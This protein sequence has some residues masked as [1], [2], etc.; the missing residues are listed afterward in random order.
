MHRSDINLAREINATNGKPLFGATR[1]LKVPVLNMTGDRSPHVDATV[2]FNG[3]LQPNK[4]TWMKIQDCAMV[5]EEQPGKVAEAVK[6][7]VQ[8]LGYIFKPKKSQS[9]TST[10]MRT[11]RSAQ[12]QAQVGSE[13]T[14]TS[15]E[16][17]VATEEMVKTA[18]DVIRGLEALTAT[19]TAAEDG[20]SNK[21]ANEPIEVN[22]M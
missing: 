15:P 2:A 14:V 10:P 12:A 6:L 1:T 4:C 22:L 5:L 3:R 8:G 9:A 11:A 20:M 21:N 18:N 16:A 17:E 13:S 19:T 7:F